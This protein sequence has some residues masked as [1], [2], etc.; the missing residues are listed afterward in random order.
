MDKPYILLSDTLGL[1]M[2]VNQDLMITKSYNGLND[3]LEPAMLADKDL[4]ITDLTRGCPNNESSH[5]SK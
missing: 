3:T 5:R 4:A 2:Q 1:A